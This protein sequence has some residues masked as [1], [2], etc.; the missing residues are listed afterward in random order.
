M[1]LLVI[2]ILIK[3]FFWVRTF[4]ARI[5]PSNVHSSAVFAAASGGTATPFVRRT[6]F[7]QKS[8]FSLFKL[9]DLRV[10]K[11]FRR[12]ET[13][14]RWEK[15]ARNRRISIKNDLFGSSAKCGVMKFKGWSG[16][17]ARRREERIER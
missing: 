4:F 1:I 16:T 10:L 7:P 14:G 13:L 17:V 9:F 6:I 3:I 5:R 8:R 12:L 2:P 15:E 11:S